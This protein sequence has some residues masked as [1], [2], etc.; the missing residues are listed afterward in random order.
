M[1]CLFTRDVASQKFED[2]VTNF[3]TEYFLDAMLEYTGRVSR[4]ET[5]ELRT[6]SA[7]QRAARSERDWNRFQY[8][9]VHP[10]VFHRM[11]LHNLVD[12]IPDEGKGCL[13][14]FLGREVVVD[15]DLSSMCGGDQPTN[16][17][18]FE[19]RIVDVDGNYRSLITREL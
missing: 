6:M 15:P 18:V 1:S 13:L 2:G 14:T 4:E 11:S 10:V 17:I 5:E 19:S 8:F 7:E 9:R 3:K 12:V 16:G